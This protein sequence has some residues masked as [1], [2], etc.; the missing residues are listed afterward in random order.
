MKVLNSYIKNFDRVLD[1]L[2]TERKKKIQSNPVSVSNIIKDVK[3]N[4]DNAL[5]KYEIRFNRHRLF[6]K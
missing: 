3:K 5:L 4:G 2:L 1:S 6:K